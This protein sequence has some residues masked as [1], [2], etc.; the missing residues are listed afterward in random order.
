MDD[1]R[2][3][4]DCDSGYS[5]AYTNNLAWRSETQPLPPILD[6]RVLFE[7]LFGTGVDPERRRTPIAGRDTAAASSISSRRTPRSCRRRSARPTSASSTSTCRRSAKSS[8]SWRRRRKR[9]SPINPGM[10]KPYGV[11]P[12]FARALQA[13]DR[14]DHDRVPGRHDARAHVPDD[15]RRHEP[16]VSR[17]RHRRRPS[18]VHPPSGEGRPDGEGHADQRVPHE[19]AGRLAAE[20]EVDQGRRLQPARQLDDRL[21]RR[22]VRRQPP[23]ARRSA[24]AAHRPRRRATSS[25]AAG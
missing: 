6:P 12:D 17:D 23:S 25:R 21:R 13:D 14:H 22:A 24:D 18:P 8:G 7:R 11:P 20:P 3:A 10:D 9:A 16:L 5:C 19:A 4:G 15:A 2:Q 1:S